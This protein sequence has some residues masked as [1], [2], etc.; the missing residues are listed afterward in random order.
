[1]AQNPFSRHPRI[2]AAY[3]VV[4]VLLA[5]GF[6]AAAVMGAAR[7]YSPVP[8]GDMWNGYL[9]FFMEVQNGN[10]TAW[11]AQHNEH[12][13]VLARLLF[14]LDLS[15]F[16]GRGASLI[17]ANYL[18]VATSA[19]VLCLGIRRALRG[20]VD[21]SLATATQTL[22]WASAFFWSQQ[23]NLTWGFQSQFF[24]AQLLPLAALSVLA[25]VRAAPEGRLS[26]LAISCALGIA[27]CGTMA[28]GVLTLPLM[29][30][31]ALVIGIRRRDVLILGGVTVTTVLVYMSGY[32]PGAGHAP[33]LQTLRANPWGI[34]GFVLTYLGNAVAYIPVLRGAGRVAPMVVGAVMLLTAVLV[35]AKG[36]RSRAERPLTY[37]ML[38][39]IAYVCATALGTALGRLTGTLDQALISRYTTPPLMAWCALLVATLPEIATRTVLRRLALV[40]APAVL[41]A[42][43]PTQAT[44]LRRHSDLRFQK[45][46]GALALALDV[47]DERAIAPIFPFTD[48]AIAIAD[49]A[50]ERHLSVFGYPPL[51]DARAS[52]GTMSKPHTAGA[53]AGSDITIESVANGQAFSRIRGRIQR[54]ATG[55]VTER[56][57]VV[58]SDGR[59]V[60]LAL[61]GAPR[62]TSSAPEPGQKRLQASD[63]TGYVLSSAV[64]APM[65]LVTA[66]GCAFSVATPLRVFS[67]VTQ[68]PAPGAGLVSASALAGDSGYS[69]SDIDKSRFKGI[70]VLGSLIHAD[71]DTGS[72]SFTVHRDEHIY[73]RSGPTAGRQRLI[74]GTGTAPIPL[75][76]LSEW[77]RISF[78][79]PRLPDAFLVTIRD[80]GDGWGEWSAIA[81]EDGL[82]AP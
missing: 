33:L 45:E 10:H 53:C 35:A 54:P 68:T 81:L 41:L 24:L 62:I 13:I 80:D 49:K 5:A 64:D 32:A 71:K 51:V 75:P 38:A 8:L 18:L 28:N 60:G 46:L 27:A 44:A 7:Y 70:R 56:I 14:W 73:Y 9:D 17:V 19:S 15:F 72:V 1:M 21:S 58:A 63:F 2:E 42:L 16:D 3:R 55:S 79:D 82:P 39:F 52:I 65:T 77:T 36:W 57:D 47:R 74:F 37:A 40:L 61:D 48:W 25:R 66:H 26:S 30:A 67:I 4:M 20:T 50:S 29:V 6:V 78:D 59:I 31:Y 76:V 69:G 11:W 34:A 23:E 12:R 43:I 22:V